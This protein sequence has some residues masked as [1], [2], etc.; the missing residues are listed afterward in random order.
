MAN[1]L[2]AKLVV[3]DANGVIPGA[4]PAAGINFSFDYTS[5]YTDEFVIGAAG[6]KTIALSNTPRVVLL[7]LTSG[8]ALV[9][10]SD[11][12]G[13]TKVETNLD[14]TDGGYLFLSEPNNGQ[15]TNWFKL[16]DSGPGCAGALYAWD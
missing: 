2:T 4:T 12:A 9:E 10:M 7:F 11:D 13:V 14:A 3:T 15:S 5:K 1:T 16:T 6:N 8:S